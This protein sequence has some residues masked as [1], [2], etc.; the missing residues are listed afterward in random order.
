MAMSISPMGVPKPKAVPKPGA[1]SS[2]GQTDAAPKPRGIPKKNTRD[3]GKSA[4]AMA[5]PSAPPDPFGAAS[6][7]GRLGGL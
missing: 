4:P 7:T 5:P 6:G 3:Y 2:V 1:V